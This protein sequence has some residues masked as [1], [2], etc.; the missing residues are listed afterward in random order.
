MISNINL[1]TSIVNVFV[2]F[3]LNTYSSSISK[4]GQNALFGNDDGKNNGK[5]ITFSTRG[6]LIVAGSNSS[7][8]I[9][10]SYPNK[11]NAGELYKYKVLSVHWNPPSEI[12]K[13]YIYCNG[14]KILNFTSNNTTGT[15][16]TTI[17]NLSN[18]KDAPLKGNIAFFSVYKNNMDDKT[19]KL[20]H[21]V[22]C[23][24]YKIIHDPIT[25][26]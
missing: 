16:T 6:S 1:N 10:N 24:R 15:S 23:E 21:K 19:I 5:Y 2:V 26:N 17:G 7:R 18:G 25:I 13:S 20:H 9:V 14:K 3:S 11:A 12:N 4:Y 22:L 8:D